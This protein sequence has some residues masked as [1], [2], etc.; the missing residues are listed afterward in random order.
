MKPSFAL[1]F[2]QE[3]VGLL[4]LTSTGWNSLGSVRFD[5][6][7]LMDSLGALRG[8]AQDLSPDGFTSVLV[9]PKSEVLYT[10][11]ITPDTDAAGQ[12][13]AVIAALEGRT[14]YA[15]DELAFD[16]VEDNGT[17]RVAAV[18]RETLAEAEAFAVDYRFQPVGFTAR[19]EGDV[20]IGTPWFGPTRCTENLPDD[21]RLLRDGGVTE[22]LFAPLVTAAALADLADA[23]GIEPTDLAEPVADL[24][25]DAPEISA[26]EPEPEVT[27][28]E[29]EGFQAEAPVTP[30]PQAPAPEPEPAAE[31]IAPEPEVLPEPEPEPAPQPEPQDEAWQDTSPVISP[32]ARLLA[33]VATRPQADS[34]APATL[35]ARLAAAAAAEAEAEA[36]ELPEL[37]EVPAPE[38]AI[39]STETPGPDEPSVSEA[40]AAEEDPEEITASWPG[41]ED[42]LPAGTRAALGASLSATPDAAQAALNATAPLVAAAPRIAAP[43]AQRLADSQPKA[44][45]G[46]VPNGRKSGKPPVGR[47]IS[48]PLPAAATSPRVTAKAAAAEGESLAPFGQRGAAARGKPRYLGLAMTGALLALLL[49][50]AVWAAIF[51]ESP[52][53]RGAV[54]TDA[55]AEMLADGEDYLGEADLLPPATDLTEAPSGEIPAE[56]PVETAEAPQPEAETAL[57]ALAPEAA[58]AAAQPG[59]GAPVDTLTLPATD[60]PVASLAQPAP[61]GAPAGADAAPNASGALPAFDALYQFDAEGRILPTPE[62]VVTPDGIRLVAA[63]PAKIPPQRPADLTPTEAPAEATDAA[64]A[65]AAGAAAASLMNAPAADPDAAGYQSDTALSGFRPRLRPS[66]LAPADQGALAEPAVQLV[67]GP[68][69]RPAARPAAVEAAA[70]RAEAAE[71]SRIAEAAA[72]AASAASLA[73]QTQNLAATPRPEARPRGIAAAST[74]RA[75]VAAAV[76]PPAQGNRRVPSNLHEE[77]EDDEPEVASAR[78]A[79][80]IPTRASVARQATVSGAINL[81]RMNLIGVFGTT[82]NRHALVREDGGRIRRVKVGD[83][84]DGGRVTAIGQSNL[85]YQKGNRAVQ[86]ALPRG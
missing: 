10:S 45:G 26:P 27:L 33:E 1:L 68:R 78:A 12:E 42:E 7:D 16:W 81:G 83:R 37:T 53:D 71:A 64:A 35:A 46:A 39:P 2:S 48:A 62:G 80:G 15:I 30:E 9:L 8:E 11:L 55:D 75:S 66:A 17:L 79:P 21:Q 84:L 49:A 31:L 20:F 50:V 67:E 41:E 77:I 60:T 86:L 70:R 38:V 63:R 34:H 85:S 29:P 28:P 76:V 32:A 59:E 82:G 56:T 36:A 23:N 47:A 51:L 6:P 52:A 22:G 44:I 74:A 69:R 13:Q 58:G 40:M 19:P 5:D 25:E 57:A 73:A 24:P 65:A 18:A 54:S 72:A 43:A 14:P 4:H 3:N 61:G